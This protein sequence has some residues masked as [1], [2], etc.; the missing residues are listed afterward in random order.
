M[1]L[2]YSGQ[3]DNTLKAGA[4]LAHQEMNLESISSLRQKIKTFGWHRKATRKIIF[5]LILHLIVAFGGIVI[6]IT[7]NNFSIQVLGMLLS[8]IGS[9]GVSTNTH[10]SSHYAT[11]E[12][13]WLKSGYP[14]PIRWRLGGKSPTPLS[15]P[16]LGE[17]LKVCLRVNTG[18][19]SR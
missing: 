10:T 7:S 14:F 17:K 2:N 5:E 13:K 9:L 18:R 11:S 3:N 12:R 16:I 19:A 4:S 8:T 6:V 15:S 1:Q